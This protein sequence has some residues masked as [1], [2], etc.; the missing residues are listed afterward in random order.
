MKEDKLTSINKFTFKYLL[1]QYFIMLIFIIS[2]TRLQERFVMI[3]L[4]AGV[5]T[6]LMLV[7]C[8]IYKRNP[9]SRNLLSFMTMTLI[10]MYIIVM[11]FTEYPTIFIVAFLI[12]AAGILVNDSKSNIAANVLIILTNAGIFTYRYFHGTSS[13][14]QSIVYVCLSIAYCYCWLKVMGLEGVFVRSDEATIL[15]QKEEQEAKIVELEQASDTMGKSIHNINSLAETLQ[16]HMKESNEAISNISESATDTADSIMKQTHLTSEIQ[17]IVEELQTAITVVQNKVGES[18]KVTEE[19]QVIM[20]NLSQKTDM[21]V[22]D[23]EQV[24]EETQRISSEIES[25]KGITDSI[26]QI[27]NSTNLLALNASIEAARA[28]EVGKGFAVVADEIRQLANDTK[29]ATNKINEVL[30][31][32]IQSIEKIGGVVNVTSENVIDEAKLM[33]EANDYFVS[34]GDKLKTSHRLAVNLE[35]KS[36]ILRESNEKF[37]DQIN[38]LSAMSEEVSAQACNTETLQNSSYHASTQ[39]VEELSKLVVVANDLQ[40]Q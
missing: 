8:V 19:G 17:N 6:M 29:L 35:N 4:G 22:R 28:G 13:L 15:K 21:I 27:T 3:G 23:S 18:V 11:L 10:F 30:D 34:I 12:N 38:N 1:L 16:S 37:V 40:A 5:T 32:F 7:A 33:K 26:T 9:A 14:S 39:I 36:N 20:D 24:A 2:E 25:I 31:R